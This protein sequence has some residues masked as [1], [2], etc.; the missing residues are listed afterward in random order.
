[1]LNLHSKSYDIKISTQFV[2]S[3][4]FEIN[5]NV[6]IRNAE[7]TISIWKDREIIWSRRGTVTTRGVGGGEG[8]N[9]N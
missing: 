2:V 8:R 5:R 1:M 4:P 3:L 6:P 7:V 9:K